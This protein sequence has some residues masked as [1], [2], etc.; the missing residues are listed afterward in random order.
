MKMRSA[1][2]AGSITPVEISLTITFSQ[3]IAIG[4][5]QASE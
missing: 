3:F 5:A 2:N 1:E 4:A